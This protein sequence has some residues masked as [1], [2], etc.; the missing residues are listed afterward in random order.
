ML[1][2]SLLTVVL[3]WNLALST[4][5]VLLHWHGAQGAVSLQVF[6]PESGRWSPL[7]GP[8]LAPAGDWAL[9]EVAPGQWLPSGQTCWAILRPFEVE[10]AQPEAAVLC[11]AWLEWDPLSGSETG[12]APEFWGLLRLWAAGERHQDSRA[13]R[14][15]YHADGSLVRR[16]QSKALDEVPG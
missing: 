2:G 3:S 6:P 14:W 10:P 9:Q 13:V 15:E 8:L 7:D 12:G 4:F 11:L 1:G 5:P 16:P